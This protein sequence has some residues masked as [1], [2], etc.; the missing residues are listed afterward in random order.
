MCVYDY[1]NTDFTVYIS[2]GS[3][4]IPRIRKLTIILRSH[5]VSYV[6]RKEI[7][8]QAANFSKIFISDQILEHCYTAYAAVTSE[9]Q[10]ANIVATVSGR[11]LKR[12]KVRVA[13]SGMIL[14]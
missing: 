8:L 3:L 7:L 1:L 14:M 13:S 9:I 12:P 2:N 6:P 10:T 4:I 5:L 11:K